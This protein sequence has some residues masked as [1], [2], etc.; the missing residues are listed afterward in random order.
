MLV[1]SRKP[2]EKVR[3]GKDVTV[4]VLE[5]RG[6]QVRIGFAAPAQVHIAR[7]ELYAPLDGPPLRGKRPTRRDASRPGSTPSSGLGVGSG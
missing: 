3:I 4:V 6:K 2:G 5:V 7:Q 1:L